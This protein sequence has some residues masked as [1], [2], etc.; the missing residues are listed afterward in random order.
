[1][2]SPWP[3]GSTPALPAPASLGSSISSVIRALIL[4]ARATAYW[5]TSCL[6][7]RPSSNTR[8]LLYCF[9]IHVHDECRWAQGQV[10][11]PTEASAER[12]TNGGAR[13][14]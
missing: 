7:A 9:M 14:S 5:I 1:M 3:T 6:T 4:W 11:G 8:I 12:P 2:I 10:S 13:S